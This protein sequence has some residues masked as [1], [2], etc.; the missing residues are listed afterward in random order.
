MPDWCGLDGITVAEAARPYGP[1]ME[2]LHAF[3]ALLNSDLR[4]AS[5][6]TRYDLRRGLVVVRCYPPGGTV[7]ITAPS[8]V[9]QRSRIVDWQSFSPISTA[10]VGLAGSTSLASTQK[11]MA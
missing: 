10:M 4:R 2:L 6:S 7:S 11:L 3:D 5:I 8:W 9:G 1:C